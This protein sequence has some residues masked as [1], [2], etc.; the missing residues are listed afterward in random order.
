MEKEH[1]ENFKMSQVFNINKNATLPYLSIELI[2]DGRCDFTKCYYALQANKGI[3]FTMTNIATGIKKIANAPC[4]LVEDQTD[5]E[6]HYYIRYKWQ[7]RDTNEKGRFVGQFKVDLSEP[8]VSEDYN[9]P[10][11]T[12]IVPISEDIVININDATIQK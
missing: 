3:Y 11:G 12:L 4:E 6:L 10:S 2:N 8:P 9:F 7:P 5:C 1:V